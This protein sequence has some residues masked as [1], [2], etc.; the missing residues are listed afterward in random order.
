MSDLISILQ[1]TLEAA[2]YST[3]LERLASCQIV[4][5]EDASIMGF[6]CVFESTA[7]LLEGW[8]EVEKALLARHAPRLRNAPEKAWN[9]YCAFL[10]AEV[11]LEDRA[12][13]IR[14]IDENLDR[15]R[16]IAAAGL[17][18]RE[19]VA[20]ALLPILP[21]FYKPVLEDTDPIERLRKRIGSIAPAAFDAVIDQGR[22]PIEVVRLV[23]DSL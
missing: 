16:K 10:T 21:L 17:A 9:V 11:A 23:R 5:F 2:N 18:T 8:R 13:E 3:W 22:R 19:D 7:A 15:T 4:G 14:W 20:R 6:A 12:R 1:G